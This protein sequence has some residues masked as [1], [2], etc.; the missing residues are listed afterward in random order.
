MFVRRMTITYGPG[1]GATTVL[2]WLVSAT[3][4]YGMDCDSDLTGIDAAG[5][6]LGLH[7]LPSYGLCGSE[8]GEHVEFMYVY[9]RAYATCLCIHHATEVPVN[10][11]G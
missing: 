3:E 10:T 4:S 8:E 7:C 11:V 6:R 5:E 1:A 2:G 9:Q